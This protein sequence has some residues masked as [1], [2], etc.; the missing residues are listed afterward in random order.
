MEFKQETL[1]QREIEIADF[2]LKGFSLQQIATHLEVNKKIVKAHIRNMMQKLK[3][4]N[5]K[6]L[7][8]LI[9][10]NQHKKTF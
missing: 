5:L 2:L 6:D 8:E 3:A 10:L 9:S 7:I 4:E 1:L